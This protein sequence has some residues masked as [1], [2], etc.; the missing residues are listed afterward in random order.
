MSLSES[1]L[2]A[3][4]DE[5]VCASAHRRLIDQHFARRLEL[6]NNRQERNGFSCCVLAGA[7]SCG[8]ARAGLPFCRAVLRV[9]SGGVWFVR[10]VVR[11]L[12]SG[13]RVCVRVVRGLLVVGVSC[14]SVHALSSAKS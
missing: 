7:L 3:L 6:P 5:L 2:G 11:G 14:L 10:A 4:T 9:G 8:C 1:A 13:L 12:L